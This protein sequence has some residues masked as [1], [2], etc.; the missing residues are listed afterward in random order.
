MSPAYAA[1]GSARPGMGIDV[2]F[3]G[4]GWA[5]IFGPQT[6]AA[7]PLSWSL[8]D[9]GNMKKYF[10]M[11]RNMGKTTEQINYLESCVV[12]ET[13]FSMLRAQKEILKLTT[14]QKDNGQQGANDRS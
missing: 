1:C 7:S 3:R 13:L 10:D 14:L 12:N 8:G 4:D 5:S 9:D 6:L 2:G 11:G